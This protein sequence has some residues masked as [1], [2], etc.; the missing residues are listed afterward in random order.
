MLLDKTQ[1]PLVEMNF[2][3]EVH[4]EDLDLINT[5][6]E[7]VLA[8]EKEPNEANQKAVDDHYM[9]WHSHTVAH[10][11]R[12]EEKMQEMQFPPYPIHKNEHDNALSMMQGIFKKWQSSRDIKVIKFYMIEEL[13]QWLVNHIATMDTVTAHFF[14]TGISPCSMAH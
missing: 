6:F 9:I 5:L 10:F 11:S 8:Y 13:P 2:M 12:E 7:A 1:L 4:F 14:K 3:N